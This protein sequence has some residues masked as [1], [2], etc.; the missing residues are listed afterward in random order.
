VRRIYALLGAE[1]RVS[2]VRFAAEH[3]YNQDSRE[4]MYSW[5]ARWLKHAPA[6]TRQAERAFT[7][8][9]LPD[10]LVFHQRPLPEGAVTA[11]ALTEAWMA[12]AR[13]QLA[14][15]PLAVRAAALRHALGFGDVR[16][17]EEA[18]Q[19][20]RPT[21]DWGGSPPPDRAGSKAG[22]EP[23]AAPVPEDG[24]QKAAGGAPTSSSAP[25]RRPVVQLAG[26][27]S[28]VDR[29]L[30]AAGFD[31]RPVRFTPFDE[32][33]AAKVQYFDTYNRTAAS[34]RVADIVAA[35]RTTPGAVLVAD[36]DEALAGA[37]ASAVEMP[38][39]AILD[40][41]RFDPTRD[42]AFLEHLEIPGIR[43]AGGLDT[44]SE[45]AGPRLLFHN[46]GP[47]FRA[48]GARAQ[49]ERLTPAQ[50]VSL[51]RKAQ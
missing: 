7:P 30:R 46:T 14:A 9:A 25:G 26:D 50:I 28:G 37:L 43:R 39:L 44:A 8:A 31:V 22:Q 4:E 6:D 45:M 23:G 24:A 20:P 32:A 11:E 16:P 10:L 29:P 3:N 5:M 13:R 48:P 33:A 27:V 21:S 36:G 2:A 17:I 19:K 12:A 42:E 49:Q 15:A 41:G 35:L 47:A 34:Q 18:K 51:V 38:R 40:A 1:D